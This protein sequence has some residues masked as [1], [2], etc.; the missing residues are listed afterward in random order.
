M[1]PPLKQTLA[2]L[3]HYYTMEEIMATLAIV[4]EEQARAIPVVDHDARLARRAWDLT[5]RRL[6]Q[7]T[8]LVRPFFT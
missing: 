3:I 8:E 7:C 4:A 1:P 6:R 2:Q 5:A